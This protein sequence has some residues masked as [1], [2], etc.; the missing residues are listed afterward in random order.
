VVA[1]PLRNRLRQAVSYGM[2]TS[3]DSGHRHEQE[4]PWP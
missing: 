4:R 1:A 2:P 3:P